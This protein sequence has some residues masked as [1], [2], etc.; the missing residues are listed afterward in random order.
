VHRS[1]YLFI[2]AAIIGLDRWTKHILA[3]KL[4]LYHTISIIPGF[5]SLTHVRNRGAA[6][7]ILADSSSPLRT[8]FLIAFSAISVL[9]LIWLIWKPGQLRTTTGVALALILGGA[10]GNLFDRIAYGEVVDFLLFYFRQWDWPAFNVADSA[11]VIG[12]LLLIFEAL[13]PEKR[14]ATSPPEIAN[15]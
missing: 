1:R 6:F 13:F 7:S 15:Q 2:A 5:F 3:Q 8:V 14:T 10:A 12:G 9:I 11:I 4:T